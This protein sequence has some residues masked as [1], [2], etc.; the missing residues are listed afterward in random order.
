MR[1]YLPSV[2]ILSTL[3]RRN[4]GAVEYPATLAPLMKSM[5]EK[6]KILYPYTLLSTLGPYFVLSVE[7]LI[8]N[9]T[10][11]GNVYLKVYMPT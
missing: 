2:E 9:P 5:G 1:Y 4:P 8:W 10:C 7:M 6:M 3:P 11:I